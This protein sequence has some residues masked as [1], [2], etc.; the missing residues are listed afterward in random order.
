MYNAG[1]IARARAPHCGLLGVTPEEVSENFVLHMN[2]AIGNAK[3][4]I[5]LIFDEIENISPETAAS[6]HWREGHHTLLFW[7]TIRSYIQAHARGRVAL[8]LVGTSP[9]ILELSKINDV[10][11]PVYLFA[12]K[13]FIPNLTFDE[14]REMVER[15]GYLMGLE[16]PPEIVSDLQKAFGGHPFFTRQVCSKIHQLASLDRPL[17]V[18]QNALDRAKREFQGQLETYLRDII[19][20]L[21]DDYPAEFQI[22]NAVLEGN[23]GELTEY[24]REA[25]E[26]IDHLIG[27]GLVERIGEDFDIKFNAIKDALRHLVSTERV[28]DPWAEISRRRNVLE[29]NIRIELFHWSKGVPKAEW[30]EV[31]SKNLSKTRFGQLNST[32]PRLL[33]SSR[34]KS[35]I[36]GGPSDVPE[37]RARVTVSWRA[38]D[39]H[40]E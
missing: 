27:Y 22:I 5:L 2:N 20:Q 37:S 29:T 39:T 18:S 26:L 31:L 34:E 23:R 8:C 9:R 6:T 38:A 19:K 33:F 21:K 40:T 3:N 13:Q 24:D 1:S 7:Q 10:A 4:N 28:E 36:P 14:T 32:E 12:Q 30:Q 16:F 35:T 15:L 25:P 11:N 17:V